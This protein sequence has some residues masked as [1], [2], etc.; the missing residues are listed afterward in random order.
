MIETEAPAD[1]LT[2]HSTI[3]ADGRYWRL[4]EPLD[5]SSDTLPKY[6]CASY[7][8][9]DG[10][11]PNPVHPSILMSDR[12]LPTFA[13]VARHAPGCAIWIDAFCVPVEPSKKRP[14]LESLGFIFSRADCVVAVVA[15]ASLA[16]MREMEATEAAISCQLSPPADLSRRPLDMLD[17]DMWI[18][19]VWT[20]Q[21]VVNN[22]GP[23]LFASTVQGEAAIDSMDVLKA[24]GGYSL[25]YSQLHSQYADID[26]RNVLDFESLLLDCQMAAYAQRS[27]FVIMSGLDNRTYLEPANFFYSMMGALTTRPSSRTT[28]PTLEGLAERFMELCEEKGDYSFIFSA[29]ERDARLGLHWRPLPGVLKPVLTWHCYGEGQPGRRVDGG[30]LLENV[31][32]FTPVPADRHDG[33]AF[34]SWVRK[35]VSRWIRAFPDSE[36]ENRSV[37][38]RRA[39]TN[40]VGFTGAGGTFLTE[41]GVFYAQGVLPEGLLSICVSRGIQWT[42][43]AP[44]IAQVVHD[45]DITYTPGVFIGNV[46]S[47]TVYGSSFML[48]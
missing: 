11:L 31:V 6:A 37:L 19:S 48:Y 45:G 30:I 21:E 15:S 24:I 32:V 27:A 44:A 23:L 34:W 42:F 4:T 26:H 22:S 47:D 29:R 40:Y 35:F 28:K 41:D 43:G 20:Y 17:T 13:A 5:I 12:T 36:L 25:A 7:V 39:L 2:P 14:T 16:A 1:G 33:D 3:A 9:G 18:R 10:R 8:W 38:I 46:R